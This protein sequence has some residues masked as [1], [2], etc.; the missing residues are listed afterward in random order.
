ML[1]INPPN[2]TTNDFTTISI[3]VKHLY[4]ISANAINLNLNLNILSK[5]HLKHFFAIIIFHHFIFYNV[6]QL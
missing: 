5:F 6:L 2:K 3:T 4:N 1:K